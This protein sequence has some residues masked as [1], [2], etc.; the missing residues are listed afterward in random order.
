ML[1]VAFVSRDRGFLIILGSLM[2][3]DDLGFVEQEAQLLAAVVHGL[4]AGR[5]EPFVL[6]QPQR[7]RQRVDLLFQLRHLALG[8]IQVGLKLL[9]FLA[10]NH[11]GS[12]LFRLLCHAFPSVLRRFIA[13]LCCFYDT[14]SA[15]NWTGATSIPPKR[16]LYFRCIFRGL[17][18]FQ[19]LDWLVRLGLVDAQSLHE[20]AVLLGCQRT[21]FAFLAWPLEAATLQPFVQQYEA[22]ALP[23]QRLDPIP[24]PSAEQEQRVAERIQVKLQPHQR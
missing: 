3:S 19:S 23:V 10:G 20:P 21:G 18:N 15:A 12:M 24:P 6:R 1:L 9:V 17:H 16:R 5:A 13:L 14:I 11:V 4:F 2:V 22:V 8:R 7:F